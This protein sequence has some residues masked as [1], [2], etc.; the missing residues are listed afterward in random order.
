L[1]IPAGKLGEGEDPL[2]CAQRELE[3]ETGCQAQQWRLLSDFFSAPGFCDEH[4]YLYLAEGLNFIEAHPDPDEFVRLE[5]IPLDQ[6][7][8]MIMD[9]RIQDAKTL[10][11]LLWYLA[12]MA[13]QG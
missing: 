8:A 5:K 4:M 2:V 1:E 10:V 7:R 9:G 12:D 11:A 3:E 13:R 6:I